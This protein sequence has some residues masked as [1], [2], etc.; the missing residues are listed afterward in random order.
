MQLRKGSIVILRPQPKDLVLG[1]G[2]PETKAYYVYIL[3]NRSGTVYTGVTNDLMRR[4]EEHRAGS[5]DSFTSRYKLDRLVYFEETSDV[6]DAIAREKQ[7]K[8]WTRKRK[9][10]LIRTLNP[11]W[12]D[13]SDDWS[14]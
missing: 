5:A 8:G 2:A 9:L 3:T 14:D 7:I 6:R 10:E 12:R 4:L 1:D 13:L 11:R